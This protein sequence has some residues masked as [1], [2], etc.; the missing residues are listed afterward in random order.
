MVDYI[1]IIKSLLTDLFK[2]ELTEEERNSAYRCVCI[3]AYQTSA[4]RTRWDRMAGCN[5]IECCRCKYFVPP[6]DTEK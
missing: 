5:F 1:E 6:S 2:E 3:K 4:E